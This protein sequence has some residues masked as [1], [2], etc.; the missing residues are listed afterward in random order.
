MSQDISRIVKNLKLIHYRE[1]IASNIVKGDRQHKMIKTD[2]ILRLFIISKLFFTLF[3]AGH[4][5]S[6]D[7]RNLL[8]VS[9][10]LSY[11][12]T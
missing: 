7:E 12:W 2:Q 10:L 6:L 11:L 5:H 8:D 4:Q 1:Q 3:S 9:G